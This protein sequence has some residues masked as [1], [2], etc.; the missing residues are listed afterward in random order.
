MPPPAAAVAEGC[1]CCPAPSSCCGSCGGAHH[2]RHNGRIELQLGVSF[3]SPDPEGEISAP[4]T[5]PDRGMWDDLDYDL[6]LSGRIEW[7]FAN[8]CGWELALAGT[9][10][11]Q[12]D[13]ATTLTNARLTSNFGNTLFPVVG[14]E[15]EALLWDINLTAVK[16]FTCSRCFTA[17]WGGGIRYLRFDEESAFTPDNPPLGTMSMD[18]DNGLLA[19]EG[20][21][22][23]SWSLS[24]CW[25]LF[26]RAS[27]F[28]GWMHTRGEG[29][30]TVA[31][32]GAV[33]STESRDEF[34][35]GGEIEVALRWH[36]SACWTLSIGYDLLV[37]GEVTRA[38]EAI[39][40]T[41]FG[42]GGG[43]DL[44]P[45]F[46]DEWI[47]CHRVYLGLAFEL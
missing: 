31:G 40:N 7:T 26:G 4:S 38:Y 6:E 15:S 11:G 13:E 34:G 27:V 22:Q 30:S 47:T 35:Y 39:D 29:A 46:G 42:V 1:G 23:A 28:G 10:W 8:W 32:L 17:S 43:A 33:D 44:G 24:R 45:I 37:M 19:L 18:V 41:Q 25:E 16:P 20:V 14:L 36:M 5:A 2:R 9:Y 21:V 3:L 12:W